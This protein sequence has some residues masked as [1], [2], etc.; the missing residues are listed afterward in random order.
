MDNG[1][2]TP[3]TQCFFRF[4][5]PVL[6]I[7]IAGK[8]SLTPDSKTQNHSFPCQVFVMFSY[9]LRSPQP[10]IPLL[11]NC[12]PAK[13]Q[14]HENN[15]LNLLW[16]QMLKPWIF[17]LSFEYAQAE[18]LPDMQ[19]KC[20]TVSINCLNRYSHSGYNHHDSL[21]FRFHFTFHPHQTWIKFYA[22]VQIEFEKIG[23]YTL[24]IISND[25]LLSESEMMIN[26]LFQ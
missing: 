7:F 13:L 1:S 21:L 25:F 9:V 8:Q 20:D 4:L 14:S 26:I 3:V 15:F 11:K 22:R 17:D 5:V 16:R 12:Q 18:I 23:K 6:D 10:V 24:Y 2:S 19:I